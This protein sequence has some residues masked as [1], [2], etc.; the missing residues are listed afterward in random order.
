MPKLLFEGS[1][2]SFDLIKKVYDAVEEIAVDELGL[3]YFPNQIEII[4]SEQMLDA[5]S[6]VG[7][8]IMYQHWSFGKH[9]ARDSEAYRKGFQGLAYEIVINSSPCISY[10]MEENTMTMQTLV[11]AHA[12][13]GHNSFFKNN[14][15]FLEWTDAESILDY[16]IFAKNYI[17]KCEEKYGTE[18]VEKILDSCHALMNHGVFKYK[19]PPKLSVKKEKEQQK[20]RERYIQRH[21]NDLWRTLPEIKEEEGETVERFPKEPEENILYFIE[22]YSPVLENWQREL[23]RIVRTVAQY[24][25]PQRQTKVMNEGWATFTHYFIMNRLH[26]KG[27]INDGS[28]LEFLSSHTNVIFQPDFDDKRYSGMN[29]YALGFNMFV[30]IK[31]ICQDPTEEDKE[32]FP[33][34][35]GSDWLETM[36]F[37]MKN[38]RDESFIR[39]YLSPTMIRKFRLFALG[40]DSKNTVYDVEK[41]HNER[42]YKKVRTILANQY[43]MVALEPDIQIWNVDLKGNRLLTLRHNI[44]DQ[45]ALGKTTEEVMKHVA[46]L[47]GYTSIV[48]SVNPNTGAEIDRTKAEK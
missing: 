47:W 2:W 28:F 6:S 21:L 38:F 13:F 20:K 15:L 24:F 23:I 16:M 1:E 9:F 39:Q 12:A 29:P 27:L 17:N 34:I 25:Y 22:K 10:L 14:H 44:R 48:I 43:D 33:D 32:W 18:E 46:R 11:I 35:A 45:K 36:H 42:G 7:M 30:D 31:R 37:A 40:D 5:Y 26:E 41:I 19:R 3:S 8:P 4:S